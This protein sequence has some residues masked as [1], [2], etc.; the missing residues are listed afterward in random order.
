M[1]AD[2]QSSETPALLA[3][4]SVLAMMCQADFGHGPGPRS[5]RPCHQSPIS[6]AQTYR[7]HIAARKR[8]DLS[9]HHAR[10]AQAVDGFVLK[11]KTNNQT[12][13]NEKKPETGDNLVS[14]P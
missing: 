6:G 4:N 9:E 11:D 8:S 14:G 2:F 13:Q 5:K 1:R 3:L 10:L 12:P 7:V